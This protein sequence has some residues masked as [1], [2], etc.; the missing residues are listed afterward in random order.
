VIGPAILAKQMRIQRV[1]LIDGEIGG[2]WDARAEV[3]LLS[4]GTHRVAGPPFLPFSLGC[5]RHVGSLATLCSAQGC[6][7][8]V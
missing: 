7:P 8:A 3:R 1:D 4:V 2:G 5:N 6:V